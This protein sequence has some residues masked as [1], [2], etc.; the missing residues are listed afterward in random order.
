MQAFLDDFTFYDWLS[1]VSAGL[2]ALAFAMRDIRWLRV[3]TIVACAID[4]GVYYFIRPGQPLWVQFGESLLFILINAYQLFMLWR[5]KQAQLLHGELAELFRQNFT[6]F[7][8]GEFRRL[9]KLGRWETLPAGVRLL[10]RGDAV[11]EVIFFVQG[12]ADVRL[13][14]D[15]WV[16]EM[17]SGSVAG[18]VSFLKG[19]VATAHVDTHTESRLFMLAHD[20]I[21]DMKE[22][23]PELYMKV[24]YVLGQHVA[25]KLGEANDRKDF[26]STRGLDTQSAPLVPGVSAL[27]P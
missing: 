11:Q 14:D 19:G 10:T 2:F 15:R 21:R 20:T 9:V 13:D 6:L 4:L 5:E 3:L 24:S 12:G 17:V 22:R 7:T 18:E 8:P 23:F 25:I 26:T 16:G 1:L 27:A